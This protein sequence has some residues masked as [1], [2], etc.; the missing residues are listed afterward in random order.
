VN[1]TSSLLTSQSVLFYNSCHRPNVGPIRCTLSQPSTTRRTRAWINSA[2]PYHAYYQNQKE[3][4]ARGEVEDETVPQD[5]QGEKDEKMDISSLDLCVY[6]KCFS[7]YWKWLSIF[8]GSIVTDSLWVFQPPSRSVENWQE[9]RQV[10]PGAKKVGWNWLAR[11]CYCPNH[12]TRGCR[13]QL[14][15]TPTKLQPLS[16]SVYQDTWRNTEKLIVTIPDLPMNF[17]SVIFFSIQAAL[18]WLQNQVI[19]YGEDIDNLH[20][21]GWRFVGVQREEKVAFMNFFW[22]C[23]S[24]IV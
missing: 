7:I 11:L 18:W 4:L 23:T 13:C 3:K 9:I 22:W 1:T 21:P 8:T 6:F 19:L 24:C 17:H 16:R 14:R 20:K 10:G 12:W 5:K 2:D 15:I